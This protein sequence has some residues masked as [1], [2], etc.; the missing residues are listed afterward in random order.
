[1]K[2]LE[3]KQATI[4]D[5]DKQ[6]VSLTKK[7]L[8]EFVT[9]AHDELLLKCLQLAADARSTESLGE[10]VLRSLNYDDEVV[11]MKRKEVT[12]RIDGHLNSVRDQWNAKF[13]KG[14]ANKWLSG[15]TKTPV[16]F[17]NDLLKLKKSG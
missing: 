11:D 2:Q 4:K 15:G 16:E 9:L 1:M 10:R 3:E 8:T 6:L 17:A 5:L 14:F 12:L 7:P 13:L